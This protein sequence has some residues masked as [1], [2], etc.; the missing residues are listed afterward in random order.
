MTRG[1]WLVVHLTCSTGFC[2]SSLK[3]L[4]LSPITA[5]HSYPTQAPEAQPRN[6]QFV[7][8][9]RRTGGRVAVGAGSA[10]SG[11]VDDAYFG[12]LRAVI[13]SSRGGAVNGRSFYG[14]PAPLS[15]GSTDAPDDQWHVGQGR[16]LPSTSVDQFAATLARWFGASDDEL[17]A[18]LPNLRHFGDRASRP[19][20][21]VNLGF[22][23]RLRKRHSLPLQVRRL[24]DTR[25]ICLPA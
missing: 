24:R 15:V 1:F 3:W 8:V 25:R 12:T 23:E 14:R 9:T 5:C 18:V 13:S 16:L 4:G 10:H 19:D 22:I 11:P 2:A 17:H 6:P 21:P 20:Y 7:A